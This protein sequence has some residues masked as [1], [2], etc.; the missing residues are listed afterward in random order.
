MK[1]KITTEVIVIQV[2]AVELPHVQ[3][4]PAYM[5]SMYF[6]TQPLIEPIFT[7]VH[8]S[9][10]CTLS[11]CVLHVTDASLTVLLWSLYCCYLVLNSH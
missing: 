3:R 4:G 7:L 10:E 5:F 2:E 1:K 11:F 6:A 8:L 9:F